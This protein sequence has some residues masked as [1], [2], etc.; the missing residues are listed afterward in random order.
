[1]KKI[2]NLLTAAFLLSAA[3]MVFA[4]DKKNDAPDKADFI[5][6]KGTHLS[7]KGSN[8]Y[9]VGT[10]MWYGGYLGSAGKIGD[11][12]RLITEL[13]NLKAI[14]IN[15][16]RVLAVSEAAAHNS[17]IRPATTSAFGKHDEDLLAGLDF[18]MAEIAKRD[19]TAVIYLNNFWQWSGGMT[20][21]MSWIEG[22]P[23]PDPNV[24]GNWEGFAAQS[25][26]F[27]QSK[28]ANDEY[29]K[30]I[31]KIVTRVN[32]I[33]GKS[34]IDDP[35]ILSWQLAN[36]PR[37]GN[38]KTT[39]KEK[40]IYVKWINDT[41]KYIHSLDTNHMVSTGAEGL[42]GA[43]NDEKLYIDAHSSPY[44]DYLTYHMW[45]RNWGWY[46]QKKPEQTWDNAVTK[47]KEYLNAHIDIAKKMNKPIVLEEFGL[48]RDMGSYDVKSS[49][50]YRDKFYRIVFDTVYNRTKAGD[51]IVGFNFWA[52]NGAARTTQP[53]HWWHA[54]DD[55]MGDPPQEEQGMYGV[56][57]SDISTILIIKEYADK[58]HALPK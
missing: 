27:Y 36:E 13:D 45:V 35:A 46:E 3:S 8:Y 42:M 22:K 54:G 24:D 20:Q 15:N 52:W 29:R 57:D 43:M 25:A 50:R 7:L 2:I 30:T 5:S 21:Y 47:G 19:I 44:V 49:T 18:F 1:M 9:V 31:K 53:N 55:F 48:D 33:T 58:M 4:V 12:N 32:T 40:S 39:D 28:K 37:A 26:K 16:I 23:A 56:F 17:A 6:V 10:N 41:A 11:R 38:W 34:Y 14:G 51:P